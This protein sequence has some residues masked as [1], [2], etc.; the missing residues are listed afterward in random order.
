MSSRHAQWPVNGLLPQ[1]PPGRY[2]VHSRRVEQ[3]GRKFAGCY[4]DEMT[5]Q[6]G[7]A[8]QIAAPIR[9]LP[10]NFTNR[11]SIRIPPLPLKHYACETFYHTTRRGILAAA[12]VALSVPA[13]A[14]GVWVGAG[15]VGVGV[16]FGAA[17]GGY[18]DGYHGLGYH[19]Y[20][21]DD[22]AYVGRPHCRLIREHFN[23]R[24]RTVRLCW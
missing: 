2:Q 11:F 6:R 14:Q 22:F 3:W 10:R 15:P 17:W 1:P 4:G 13:N 24:L 18:Y 21:D 19:A 12:G 9:F 23:G 20:A 5:M 8:F 16:G 7:G